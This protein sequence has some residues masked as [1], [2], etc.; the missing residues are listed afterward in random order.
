M[1]PSYV[2]PHVDDAE[3]A[4]RRLGKTIENAVLADGQSANTWTEIFPGNTKLGIV[5][6]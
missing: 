2:S 6:Q 3:D 1:E 4:N 5:L